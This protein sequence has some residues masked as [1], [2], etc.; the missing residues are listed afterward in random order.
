MIFQVL[1]P[2]PPSANKMFANVAI[3]RANANG[4]LPRG[5]VKTKAYRDWRKAAVL[6]IFAHVRADQRIG[7]EVAVTIELPTSSRIDIDN[8]VKPILDALVASNRIDDDRN[9]RRLFVWRQRTLAD[10]LVSVESDMGEGR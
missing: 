10:V 9:V 5:R 3:R 4:K 6:T 8:T 1:L 7:G 2:M